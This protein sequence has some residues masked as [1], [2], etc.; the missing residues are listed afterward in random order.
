M[1]ICSAEISKLYKWPHSV[2]GLEVIVKP[3]KLKWTWANRPEP[4]EDLHFEQAATLPL[5]AWQS[6]KRH[7]VLWSCPLRFAG[8]RVTMLGM[9]G[10]CPKLPSVLLAKHL[11][12]ACWDF[13]L[14]PPPPACFCENPT[15]MGTLIFLEGMF[16]KPPLPWE[17]DSEGCWVTS[18]LGVQAQEVG[19]GKNPGWPR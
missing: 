2:W 18:V 12:G 10:P 5:H 9:T 6:R 1:Q 4:S 11:P 14:L 13:H 3:N 17:N 16:H 8:V 7:G 15:G 19:R